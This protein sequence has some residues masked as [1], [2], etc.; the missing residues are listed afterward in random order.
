MEF[1]YEW[2]SGTHNNRTLKTL[3]TQEKTSP[4]NVIQLQTN[5][6]IAERNLVSLSL[7]SRPANATRP[8]QIILM[9][10]TRD[11]DPLISQYDLSINK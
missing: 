11:I 1:Y 4:E 10:I 6:P 7:D 5:L 3:Y 9:S 2:K 8:L